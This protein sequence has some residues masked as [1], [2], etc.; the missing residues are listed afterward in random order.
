MIMDKIEKYTGINA[1][2]RYR[3]A[4]RAHEHR[5]RWVNR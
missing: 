5:Y 2:G 3:K 1:T 4:A